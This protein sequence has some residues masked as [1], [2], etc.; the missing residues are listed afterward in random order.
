M[1]V[2]QPHVD[3]PHLICCFLL[4][5]LLP[6]LSQCDNFTQVSMNQSH[7]GVHCL[8]T[9]KL[10][11]VEDV[12]LLHL[13]YT[14]SIWETNFSDARQTLQI[15]GRSMAGV[16]L[17]LYLHLYCADAHLSLGRISPYSHYSSQLKQ[18]GKKWYCNMFCWMP[19]F[20]SFSRQ[21]VTHEVT[22]IL[23][24]SLTTSHTC[25]PGISRYCMSVN[26]LSGAPM[27]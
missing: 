24:S 11:I 17:H 8:I 10:D 26:K 3:L 5:V 16:L 2:C 20:S 6:V 1:P 13:H 7:A 12:G 18:P 22:Y 19:L 21:S 27:R 15:N 9:G 14:P 4:Q 23:I 25:C